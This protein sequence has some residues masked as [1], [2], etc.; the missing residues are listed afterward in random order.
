M[1]YFAKSIGNC[2]KHLEQIVLCQRVIPGGFVSEGLHVSLLV[3][4]KQSLLS[5]SGL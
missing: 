4:F 5:T 2:F 3:V 1:S